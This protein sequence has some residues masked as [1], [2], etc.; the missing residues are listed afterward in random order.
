MAIFS[1]ETEMEEYGIDAAIASSVKVYLKQAARY[2]ILTREEELELAKAALNGDIKARNEL[3]NHNL[4]FVVSIAKKYMGKGLPLLDLIQEGNLGL[5]TAVDKF[6]I[7]KGFRFTTYAAF[8]IKQSISK[9]IK[10]QSR[11]IR[12]PIH[13]IELISSVRKAEKE[14][15][16]ILGR[17]PKTIEIAKYLN[18]EAKKVKLAYEWMKD[19][20]SLDVTIGDDEDSTLANFVED[21]AAAASFEEIEDND[22]ITAIQNVLSTLS[23]R[24]RFIIEH[25]FGI[26]LAR[27]ETLEEVGVQLGISKERVRQLETSALRKLRN[28]R[29]ASLLKDFL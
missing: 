24:E 2:S 5:L 8:W 18:L 19:A 21:D 23:E 7:E 26:G 22:R 15:G 14:L 13:V 10:E 29:R 25:R 28:P 12:I 27:A 1:I 4:R 3:V 20:S 11:S 16:Q 6:D 9:A 17:E